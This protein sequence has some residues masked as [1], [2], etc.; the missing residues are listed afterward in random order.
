M[1][2]FGF[3]VLANPIKVGERLRLNIM[4]STLQPSH[5]FLS[6]LFFMG[7]SPHGCCLETGGGGGAPIS[8]NAH[9]ESAW[10]LHAGEDE[11]LLF[12]AL[13]VIGMLSLLSH[14]QM[15]LKAYSLLLQLAWPSCDDLIM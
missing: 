8:R 3:S 5:S 10:Q 13:E 2:L 9:H 4:P 1:F 12:R 11:S 14:T 7:W 6:R 15:P